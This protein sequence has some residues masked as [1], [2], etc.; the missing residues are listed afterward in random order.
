ML[1]LLPRKIVREEFGRCIIQY[2]Y[3]AMT[4]SLLSAS[5]CFVMDIP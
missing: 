4:F 3:A 1:T 5:M 2:I